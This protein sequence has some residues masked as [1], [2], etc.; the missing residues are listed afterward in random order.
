MGNFKTESQSWEVRGNGIVL[1]SWWKLLAC[2]LCLSCKSTLVLVNEQKRNSVEP[3]YQGEGTV[4]D[5][6]PD[7]QETKKCPQSGPRASHPATGP[8]CF[9]LPPPQTVFEMKDYSCLFQFYPLPFILLLWQHTRKLLLKSHQSVVT[10]V[11]SMDSKCLTQAL[12]EQ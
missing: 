8:C 9:F 7:P 10:K 12:L 1:P 11:V 4:G 5:S 6:L 2:V 3:M